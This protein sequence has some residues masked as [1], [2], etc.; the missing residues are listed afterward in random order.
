MKLP[1][2]TFLHLEQTCST[3]QSCATDLKDSEH[4]SWAAFPK[5]SWLR[6]PMDPLAQLHK[7]LAT[8]FR[9][10]EGRASTASRAASVTAADV[11]GRG[12]AMQLAAT[13]SIGAETEA[14]PASISASAASA[15]LWVC[16]HAG[17][18]LAS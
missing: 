13:T 16:A 6:K 3:A 8:V 18:V 15:G 9:A 7:T 1:W 12:V 5:W 2:T 17:A 11:L 4:S 10:T 14:E